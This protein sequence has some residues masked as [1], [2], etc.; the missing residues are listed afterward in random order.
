MNSSINLLYYYHYYYYYYYYYVKDTFQ[1]VNLLQWLLLFSCPFAQL[2]VVF[3][4][5]SFFVLCGVVCNVRMIWCALFVLL[6]YW[7]KPKTN[8]HYGGQ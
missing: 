5:I 1:P 3:F 8:F 4:V 2:S 7:R 6:M